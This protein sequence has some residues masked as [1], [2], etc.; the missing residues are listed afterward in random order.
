MNETV[1]SPRPTPRR[2]L[3]SGTILNDTFEIQEFIASGGMGEVYRARMLTT[4]APVAIKLIKQEFLENEDVHALFLREASALDS[5]AHDS[6]VRYYISA[7]DRTLN[8]PYLA[9]EFVEGPS[10]SAFL[11]QRKLTFEEADSL[12]KR[13]AE[14]LHAAHSRNIVHRD[15]APDNVILTEGDLNRAKLIDFGIA[16]SNNLSVKSVIQDG[17]AGKY[18][19]ASPEQFGLFKRKTTDGA[20]TGSV[21][22]VSALS[23]IYSLGLVIAECLLGKPINMGSDFADAIDNRRSVPDLSG[24]DARLRPLL[25][26]MLQPR[27]E[28]RI[29]SMADVASWAPAQTKKAAAQGR[30]LVLPIAASITAIVLIGGGYWYATTPSAPP[31]PRISQEPDTPITRI[32]NY[33]RYYDADDCLLLR[34]LRI[35]ERSAS[36]QALSG[37]QTATESFEA[38]FRSVNGFAP[39]LAPVSLSRQQCDIVTFVHRLDP[40]PTPNLRASLSKAAYSPN[41]NVALQVEGAS[42]KHVE[43]L[44]VGSDGSV[45][46][47]THLI[48]RKGEHLLLE[49]RMGGPGANSDL[50]DILVGIVTPER[51]EISAAFAQGVA[52]SA[53]LS[54]L[55][56]EIER[57]QITAEVLVS[58]VNYR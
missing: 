30:R 19:Y 37:S 55:A 47:L 50:H 11:A 36:I 14:G 46:N 3:P 24:I 12:R 38:D 27:P 29:A 20:D 9:M 57:K 43:M 4:G 22:S 5:L 1:V 34:P 39:N 51:L 21:S 28:D 44:A 40:A 18:N 56:G 31:A 52:S 53:I 2:H 35:T 13:L 17:F 7:I 15:I 6:I 33:T 48:N 23:D 8:R 42:G 10:L 41:E 49:A 16:K 25:T 32:A 45:R 26:M 54:S 58:V